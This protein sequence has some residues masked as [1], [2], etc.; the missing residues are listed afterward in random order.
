MVHHRNTL[1]KL[2]KFTIGNVRT[3]FVFGFVPGAE[4]SFDLQRREEL[5]IA[6]LSPHSPL[7]LMLQVMP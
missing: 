2:K 5:S 4:R 3:C 7:R 6:A 1:P